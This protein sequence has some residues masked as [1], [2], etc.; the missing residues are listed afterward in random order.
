MDLCPSNLTG[1]FLSEFFFGKF[2][3]LNHNRVF[4]SFY[5]FRVVKLLLSKLSWSDGWILVSK[6]EMEGKRTH[7]GILFPHFTQHNAV[8]LKRI[9]EKVNFN[10]EWGVMYF[11]LKLEKCSHWYSEQR[12]TPGLEFLASFHFFFCSSSTL[13]SSSP[14]SPSYELWL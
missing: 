12:S 4:F 7:F 10:V 13:F 2:W 5:L 11:F 3:T 14:T 8:E 6:R 9:E 1:K